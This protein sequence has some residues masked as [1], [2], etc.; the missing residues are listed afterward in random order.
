[1]QGPIA[2]FVS[3]AARFVDEEFGWVGLVDEDDAQEEEGG[4][5]D[6]GEVFGPAPAE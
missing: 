4:L 2:G 1:V 6:A 5:K 3:E